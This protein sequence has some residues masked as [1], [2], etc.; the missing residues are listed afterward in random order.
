MLAN[1]ASITSDMTATCMFLAAVTAFWAMAHRLTPPRILV[2]GLAL[3]LL[4]V[5][6]FS[7]PLIA[8]DVRPPLARADR[9]QGH[10]RRR[11]AF[12]GAAIA[13]RSRVALALIGG[14]A[15]RL[16][17]RGRASSGPRTA[18]GTR[19]SA[20]FEPNRV[21]SLVGWDV[22][23]D[24]RRARWSAILRF[25][26]RPRAPSRVLHLRVR[27][28]LPVLALPEI[29][30]ERRVPQHGLGRSSSRTRRP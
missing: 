21:R 27:T 3:G 19:C 12:P 23:E 7:A 8:P 16:R 26:A 10:A 5:A 20:S 14:D 11:M 29:V 15:R 22:L 17:A 2:F 28:Q 24:Q 30:P 4:C 9:G 1:G 18:S 25:V 13:G 6:K